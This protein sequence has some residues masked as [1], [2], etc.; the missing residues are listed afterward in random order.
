MPNLTGQH[1]TQF[2]LPFSSSSLDKKQKRTQ[3]SYY[4]KLSSH[5]L[6]K[7]SWPHGCWYFYYFSSAHTATYLRIKTYSSLYV[8]RKYL[9]LKR[10]LIFSFVSNSRLTNARKYASIRDLSRSQRK[11]T[12]NIP[13]WFSDSCPTPSRVPHSAKAFLDLTTFYAP[14]KKRYFHSKCAVWGCY[15]LW[16]VRE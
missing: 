9:T 7:H 11:T 14:D 3:I 10:P 2:S 13:M 1:Q 12:D 6:W 15:D 16:Q 5:P 8:S 4:Y